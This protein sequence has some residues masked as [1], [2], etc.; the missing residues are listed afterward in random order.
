[1][2]VDKWRTP[3]ATGGGGGS[4]G[5]KVSNAQ[6]NNATRA[7][8]CHA[9]DKQKLSVIVNSVLSISSINL[10][11][12]M[13][14]STKTLLCS[15]YQFL[16][17]NNLSSTKKEFLKED[18]FDQAFLKDASV[19]KVPLEKLFQEHLASQ[20]K[21]VI[22]NESSGSNSSSSDSSD[23][24]SSDSEDDKKPVAVKRKA[25]DIAESSSSSDTSDSSDSEV[26]PVV[27]KKAPVVK[28]PPAKKLKA[29]LGADAELT[30]F[31]ADRSGQG[32]DD[33]A[34]LRAMAQDHRGQVLRLRARPCHRATCWLR[35][36][37]RGQ[38]P[39]GR[40][41]EP[42]DGAVQFLRRRGRGALRYGRG[43]QL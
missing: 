13:D 33:V 4:D 2:E 34:R 35:H 14:E 40:G 37:V 38:P 11:S 18:K 7:K 36:G 27:V 15:V 43:G 29:D 1:V 17:D 9:D 39:L 8:S 6:A 31:F 10:A 28:A 5:K 26:K 32:R 41:G 16:E 3:T 20:K 12:T 25:A 30:T 24:D 23:S 22:K 21:E 42:A 19:M